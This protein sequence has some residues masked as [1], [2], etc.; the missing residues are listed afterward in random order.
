MGTVSRAGRICSRRHLHVSSEKLTEVDI[1]VLAPP[2]QRLSEIE[3]Q[4]L[5]DYFEMSGKIIYFDDV[6]LP[7]APLLTIWACP[8]WKELYGYGFSF[9]ILGQTYRKN[10]TTFH[11]EDFLEQ[12]FQLIFSQASAVQISKNNHASQSLLSL[13]S[14]GWM[15][16]GGN[17]FPDKLNLTRASMYVVRQHY[18]KL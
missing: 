17:L 5:Y 13:S 4:I 9:S 10:A 7:D 1:V 2:K 12:R 15:E 3:S 18:L 16:R 11:N 8:K 6:G 14:G